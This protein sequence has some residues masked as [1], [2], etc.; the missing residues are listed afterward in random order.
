MYNRWDGFQY[1]DA[2]VEKSG[3]TYTIKLPFR[4]FSDIM[5]EWALSNLDIDFNKDGHCFVEYLLTN[6]QYFDDITLEDYD[7]PLN[8]YIDKINKIIDNVLQNY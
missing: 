8:D 3:N 6:C 7:F 5:L 4:D 1:H 2:E